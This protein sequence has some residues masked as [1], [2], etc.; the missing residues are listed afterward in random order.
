MK[1]SLTSPVRDNDPPNPIF[2]C[3]VFGKTHVVAI[4]WNIE[5]QLAFPGF[6]RLEDNGE[7]IARLGCSE[8]EV[9]PPWPG[10][11]ALGMHERV[12]DNSPDAV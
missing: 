2:T 9:S 11:K 10:D 4:P 12:H 3:L 8:L 1:L 5:D 6:F 7:S